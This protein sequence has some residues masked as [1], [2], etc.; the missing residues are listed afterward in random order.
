MKILNR[1]FSAVILSLCLLLAASNIWADC[2]RTRTV[3]LDNVCTDECLSKKEFKAVEKADDEEWEKIRERVNKMWAKMDHESDE[4]QKVDEGFE[5]IK[6]NFSKNVG[7][8]QVPSVVETGSYSS[9]CYEMKSKCKNNF[10]TVQCFDE[11]GNEL[12]KKTGEEAKQEMQKA[13]EAKKSIDEFMR[14]DL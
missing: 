2:F 14:F 8:N 7:T 6:G 11:N 9:G 1:L 10:C 4:R 3:C 13:E 12:W 5:N